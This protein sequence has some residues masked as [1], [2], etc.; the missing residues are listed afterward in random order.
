MNDNQQLI[1]MI[2]ECEAVAK[3]CGH[4]PGDWHPVDQQRLH[5]FVCEVCGTMGWVTRSGG[6]KRWRIGGSALKQKCLENDRG[7]A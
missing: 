4:T 5:A 1:A 7:S 2:S 3:T 6:E